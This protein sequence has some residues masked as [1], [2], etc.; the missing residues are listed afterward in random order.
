MYIPGVDVKRW[1]SDYDTATLW[2]WL[3]GCRGC[4]VVVVGPGK[5]DV[6]MLEQYFGG[7]GPGDEGLGITFWVLCESNPKKEINL[8]YFGVCLD[9]TTEKNINICR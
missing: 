3:R 9:L 4:V 1:P 2:G 7:R 6:Q 8:D 5:R